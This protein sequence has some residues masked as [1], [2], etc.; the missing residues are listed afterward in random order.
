MRRTHFLP[1]RQED[2]AEE[3]ERVERARR[4]HRRLRLPVRPLR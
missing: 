3:L 4:L 1:R 2:L